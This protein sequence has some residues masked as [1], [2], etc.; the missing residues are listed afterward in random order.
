[1]NNKKKK[2][3]KKSD[4][5]TKKKKKE[6]GEIKPK[7]QKKQKIK[8]DLNSKEKEVKID[9]N[10]ANQTE[11]IEKGVPSRLFISKNYDDD[12][13]CCYD[14]V[15]FKSF[16]NKLMFVYNDDISIISYDLVDN[17][18]INEIKNGHD[19]IIYQINHH[20]DKKHKRDIIMTIS[21]IDNNIK[22]WDINKC[23]CILDIIDKGN[24]EILSCFLSY[25]DQIYILT[26][27]N[28]GSS[29][30]FN[31]YD[32]NG[33]IIDK[34][35]FDDKCI[36]FMD[37]YYDNK[38]S[39]AFIIVCS[40]SRSLS[41]DFNEKK[42]YQNYLGT[43]NEITKLIIFDDQNVIKLLGKGSLEL[44][45]WSFHTGEI[46][47]C[48]QLNYTISG[49]CIW[50]N[51]YLV[52]YTNYRKSHS[53]DFELFD[54]KEKRMRRKLILCQKCNISLINKI[55]HPNYGECL[56]AKTNNSIKLLVMSLI[57]NNI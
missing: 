49:L 27:N 31:I 11:E 7:R 33:T 44:K 56:L 1:M 26:S 39:K 55:C 32:L 18:K 13:C 9:I 8:D 17:K 35:Y 34:I 52:W 38:L 47:E 12:I 54:L 4:H 10:D 46:L 36:D 41:Y 24:S 29:A 45:I 40:H 23:E 43:Q 3:Q 28:K 6:K 14:Y 42:I 16:D 21:I 48:I 50:N 51:R 30:P 19:N 15:V 37:I 5:L 57:K 20:F 25:N 2:T 22:V 53:C